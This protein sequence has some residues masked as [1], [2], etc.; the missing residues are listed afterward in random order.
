[1]AGE[2]AVPGAVRKAFRYGSAEVIEETVERLRKLPMGCLEIW[3]TRM[4]TV[5]GKLVEAITKS[6]CALSN[7]DLDFWSG[8]RC[9]QYLDQNEKLI[10]KKYLVERVF[11]IPRLKC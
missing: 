5:N 9:N 1:L 2:R 3:G 7:D 10:K 6:F 4:D 11:L 8:T